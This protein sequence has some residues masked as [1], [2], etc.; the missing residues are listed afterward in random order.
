MDK[1]VLNNLYSFYITAI[2]WIFYETAACFRQVV[3]ASTFNIQI[4]EVGRGPL[5][6]ITSGYLMTIVYKGKDIF[7]SGPLQ[8]AYVSI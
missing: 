1:I 8:K 7:I 6:K 2:K 4:P 3:I 5:A